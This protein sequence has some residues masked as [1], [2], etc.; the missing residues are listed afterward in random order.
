MRLITSIATSD[1]PARLSRHSNLELPLALIAVDDPMT[2]P[3]TRARRSRHAPTWTGRHAN[4]VAESL[5]ISGLK[6]L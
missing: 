3:F 4:H 2:A 1:S 5:S 6:P